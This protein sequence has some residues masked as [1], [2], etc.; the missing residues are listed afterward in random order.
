MF[1][2]VTESQVLATW[3][4]IRERIL[5]HNLSCATH[6]SNRSNPPV[7]LTKITRSPTLEHIGLQNQTFPDKASCLNINNIYGM[8][9]Y[10][11]I[12]RHICCL[13]RNSANAL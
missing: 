4:L 8:N 12:S 1:K 11:Y 10:I 13:S 9:I 7:H 2:K 3:S 6:T 5:S